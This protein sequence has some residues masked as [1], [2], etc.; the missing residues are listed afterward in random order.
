MIE[1]IRNY[2]VW[3]LDSP[4]AYP[5][6]LCKCGECNSDMHDGDSVIAYNGEYY[7][8]EECYHQALCRINEPEYVRLS[9][10]DI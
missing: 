7:C 4:V 9:K 6:P 1:M 2:D 3:K 8:G 5:K 10:D